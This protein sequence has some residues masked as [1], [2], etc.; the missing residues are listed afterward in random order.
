M[1]NLT[2]WN[3]LE[4]LQ[5][6]KG[7]RSVAHS[8]RGITVNDQ[9]LNIYEAYGIQSIF[10]VMMTIFNKKRENYHTFLLYIGLS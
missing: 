4:I 5:N 7:I 2:L 10:Q 6:N 3:P 1:N 8:R 9:I